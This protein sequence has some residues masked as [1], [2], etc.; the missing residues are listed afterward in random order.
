[1]TFR[2]H[3]LLISGLLSMSCASRPKP[4]PATTI[5]VE[6]EEASEGG[7]NGALV[8]GAGGLHGYRFK[9]TDRPHPTLEGGVLEEVRVDRQVLA[10]GERTRGVASFTPRADVYYR[11]EAS[12]PPHRWSM[13]VGSGHDRTAT[14][15]LGCDR[16]LPRHTVSWS[17]FMRGQGGSRSNAI[18]VVVNCSGEDPPPSGYNPASR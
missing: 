13:W 12:A 14:F 5:T 1:M 2:L 18:P 4:R 7:A 3:F 16:A 8:V 15:W 6:D 10:R 9:E 17:F 11:L